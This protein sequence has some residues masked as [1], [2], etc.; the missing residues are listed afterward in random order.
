MQSSTRASMVTKP[1][2]F[3]QSIPWASA[4]SR[5][6]MITVCSRLT[7]Y[8]AVMVP[9]L[10]EW[11]TSRSPPP[12]CLLMRVTSPP[13]VCLLSVNLFAGFQR[14]Y[15]F[16]PGAT[17][18]HRAGY[19]SAHSSSNWLLHSSQSGPFWPGGAV[20]PQSDS[21]VSTSAM[22]CVISCPFLGGAARLPPL[23]V[24]IY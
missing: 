6:G 20:T 22:M 5:P 18:P 3:A 9:S 24:S 1:V 7:R 15:A 17:G 11:A 14:R 10:V 23:V 4:F 13:Q 19:S 2:V 12:L 21:L 16:R 8:C